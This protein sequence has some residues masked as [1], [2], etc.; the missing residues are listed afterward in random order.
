MALPIHIICEIMMKMTSMK[1]KVAVGLT[2]R[3]LCDTLYK[4]H[5]LHYVAIDLGR[6]VAFGSVSFTWDEGQTCYVYNLGPKV[7][8]WKISLHANQNSVKWEMLSDSGV[9]IPP[10]ARIKVQADVAC[11][12]VIGVVKKYLGDSVCEIVQRPPHP[13]P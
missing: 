9:E 1:E 8:G 11:P 4:A 10:G 5:S 7:S 6:K 12:G 3:E 13:S 2:C